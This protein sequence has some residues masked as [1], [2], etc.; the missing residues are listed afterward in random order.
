M[1]IFLSILPALIGLIPVI[2]QQW[3]TAQTNAA[4]ALP[5]K[6]EQENRSDLENA[7][8]LGTVGPVELRID[9]LLPVSES[10]NT[11]NPEPSASPED[12]ERRLR[13]FLGITS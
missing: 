4:L 5:E 13:N 12:V 2:I 8:T 11:N 3:L 10:T 9:K 6:K 1:A 7:V